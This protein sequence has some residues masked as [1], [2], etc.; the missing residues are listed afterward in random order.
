MKYSPLGRTGL[1]VSRVCLGT[2]TWGVQNTQADADAQIERSAEAG[3][4]FMDTAEMYA[5]PP[6][7]DTYGATETIIGDWLARNP[8]KRAD[9]IIATKIAG[10]G[11]P[12]AREGAPLSG[13]GV[14][15]A[16][17]ASL[18]RLQTDYIDLYQLHWPNRTSPHFGKHWPGQ[19]AMP[20]DREEQV[21][22]MLDT[23]RGI[24]TCIKEG[25]IRHFG[26]SNES[27]WGV[28]Q[29]LRLAEEHGLPRVASV[30][31]EFNLLQPKDHP[32]LLEQ[33]ILEEVAYLPWSPL[34]MGVLSG[35]Y[36][37]GARPEGSRW[38][39]SP[40]FGGFRDTKQVAGAVDGYVAVAQKYGL[41]PSQLALAWVDSVAG[42]TSSIIGAT[43][44]DQLNENLGAYSWALTE[45][46]AAD[47]LAV[48]KD[49]PQPY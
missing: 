44:L 6:T 18:E 22:G 27:P 48:M 25:K 19:Y 16:V 38:A 36:A 29:Y 37:G 4:N 9:W 43:S 15:A 5:V 23:L 39:V 20:T 46:M 42:V 41:T 30:Q 13:D 21:A 7:A 49:Y 33:L 35:K 14:I 32:Y 28:S 34:G 3:V 1:E 8:A 47:V 26:V 2:M 12:W 17:E 11:L 45:D 40:N 10:P 31:N 24:D